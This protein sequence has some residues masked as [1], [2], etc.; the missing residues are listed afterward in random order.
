MFAPESIATMESLG[1]KV[2][3]ALCHLTRE[4]NRGRIHMLIHCNGDFRGSIDG[5]SI[6]SGSI[7]HEPRQIEMAVK[8][9][10]EL[11]G[12]D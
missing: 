5:T 7:S 1:W 4:T 2:S 9:H 12:C 3:K 8:I 11:V 6:H 10:N